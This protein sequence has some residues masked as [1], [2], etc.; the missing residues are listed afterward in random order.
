MR[1]TDAIDCDAC[2]ILALRCELD[3]VAFATS[4]GVA[5]IR[6][7]CRDLTGCTDRVAKASTR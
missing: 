6:W 3:P 2:N 1:P 4:A 5:G 7:V